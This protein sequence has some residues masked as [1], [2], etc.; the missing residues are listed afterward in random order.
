MRINL[1]ELRRIIRTAIL[2]SEDKR[3][4]DDTVLPGEKADD[5]LLA[6]PDLTDQQERDDYIANREKH[7]SKK[8]RDRLHS[9][10]E[11]EEGMGDE[12]NAVGAGGIAGH[13][14]GAWGPRREST[15]L[16]SKNAMGGKKKKRSLDEY[17][18]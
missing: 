12:S 11:T 6:E 10:E 13:V 7:R 9:R 16:R 2:E 14:G 15:P 1:N 17:D 4:Y 5:E 3:V 8:K 18:E